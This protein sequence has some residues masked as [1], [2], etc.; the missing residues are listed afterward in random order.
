MLAPHSW[1][2]IDALERRLQ[3]FGSRRAILDRDLAPLLGLTLPRLRAAITRNLARI[4]EGEA[5]HPDGLPNTAWALT[6]LAALLVMAQVR[7]PEAA[8]ASVQV[9]RTLHQF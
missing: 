5:F 8:A 3:P 4:P 1:P 7:T 2:V 6:E 9:I